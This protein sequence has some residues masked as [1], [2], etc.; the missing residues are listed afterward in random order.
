MAYHIE[1]KPEGEG[2]ENRTFGIKEALL[3]I[4]Q[5]GFSDRLLDE[6][7]ALYREIC[8]EME[9]TE[10]LYDDAMAQLPDTLG[11]DVRKLDQLYREEAKLTL[12]HAFTRGVVMCQQNC[13]V[14]QKAYHYETMVVPFFTTAK[15]LQ[16]FPELYRARM[17]ALD[18]AVELEAV[19]DPFSREHVISI[20]CAWDERSYA[21]VRLGLRLGFCNEQNRIAKRHPEM[22]KRLIQVGWQLAGE[23]RLFIPPPEGTEQS[24]H[25]EEMTSTNETTE[26]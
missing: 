14:P 9:E 23:I 21:M 2:A 26:E 24:D 25:I 17:A 7:I 22:R 13:F 16:T 5:N 19:S 1:D 15:G 12:S 6:M 10:Q 18:L 4:E 3:E 20:E 11:D 8:P